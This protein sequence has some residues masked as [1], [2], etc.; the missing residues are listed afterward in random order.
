MITP[1]FIL[2]LI[3]GYFLV[4]IMISYFTGKEDT[5]AGFFTANRNAPWY[6]VAFGMVGASLSGVTFISVPGWVDSSQFNYFQVVLGYGVGYFVVAY[7]LLPV[8]YN[9]NLTSIYEY[10]AKRLGGVQCI[11]TEVYV[12]SFHLK[13]LGVLL[14]QRVFRFCKNSDQGI[15]V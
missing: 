7:V 2:A 5:N 3:I 4:L 13:Q 14:G 10:L 6:V 15:V 12:H 8:Y 9:N 1:S 11:I